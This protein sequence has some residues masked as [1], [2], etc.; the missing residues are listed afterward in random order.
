MYFGIF[1]VI[2]ENQMSLL[3]LQGINPHSVK[4]PT[5]TQPSKIFKFS[6]CRYELYISYKPRFTVNLL[7][8]CA[9]CGTGESGRPHSGSS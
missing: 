8:I 9:T 3:C 6:I 1:F 5:Q 4:L 7:E 2:K